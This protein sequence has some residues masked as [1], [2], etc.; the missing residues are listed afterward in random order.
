MRRAMFVLIVIGGLV[1][2]MLASPAA[3]D[4]PQVPEE[5]IYLLCDFGPFDPCITE[6]PAGEPFY[7]AHG[8]SMLHGQGFN[9]R[10]IA[11]AI[12]HALDFKLFV[13][14]VEM[15]ADRTYHWG[16]RVVRLFVFPD[17]LTGEITFRGEWFGFCTFDD[18]GIVEGC[19]R[20]SDSVLFLTN[21]VTVSFNGNGG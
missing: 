17:G 16:P 14:G 8:A 4:P 20:P 13:D 21:E 12:G 11:P 9:Q 15:E 10:G 6:F 18:I 19:D 5:S 2:G 7:I 1:A 3:A